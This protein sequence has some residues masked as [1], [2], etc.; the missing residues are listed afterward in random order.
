MSYKNITDENEMDISAFLVGKYIYL[1]PPN[2]EKDVI[3]GKWFSWFNDKE[4]TKCLGQG[5][6]PNTIEKQIEFVESLKTKNN[7][8]VL[9]IINKTNNKHIGVVEISDIDFFN[10]KAII[11]LILGE[12][13]RPHEAALESIALMTEY[14]FDRLNLNK[15]EGGQCEDLWYWVNKLELLGYRIEGYSESVIIRDGRI[16]DGF[17]VGITAERFYKLKSERNGNI[18]TDDLTNLLHQTRRENR[19]EKIKSFFKNLY[20]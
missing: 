8:V 20:Q 6:F 4:I 2:I 17:H 9:C 10:R 11:S 18:C 5:T 7:K 15:I 14:G 16:Y 3:N 13:E 12:K 19:T 1:R